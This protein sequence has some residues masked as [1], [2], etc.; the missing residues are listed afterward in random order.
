[1]LLV[2][3]VS[4]AVAVV[5]AVAPTLPRFAG[6]A[7][8]PS[9]L[10]VGAA[11]GFVYPA[12]V[13]AAG[14]GSGARMYAWDLLGAAAAAFITSLVAIPLY[15]LTVVAMVCAALGATATLANLRRP[16]DSGCDLLGIDRPPRSSPM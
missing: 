6:A 10:L 11:T 16:A 2:T 4:C 14:P 1:L 7:V 9:L 13:N 15:G 5:F 3:G 12:A 8:T